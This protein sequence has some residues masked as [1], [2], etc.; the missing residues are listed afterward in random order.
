VQLKRLP[1][2]V[3]RRR[4]LAARYD[5]LLAGLPGVQTPVEPEWAR[6]NWQTYSVRLPG[7]ASQRAVMQALL[8]RGISTRRGVMC[9][10][11]EPAYRSSIWRCADGPGACGCEAGRCANLRNGEALQDETIALPLYHEMSAR[12]QQAVAQALRSAIHD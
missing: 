2:M 10:H 5:E 12:E 3:A 8:E 7:N 4:E 6:S 11:R 1:G 9:A